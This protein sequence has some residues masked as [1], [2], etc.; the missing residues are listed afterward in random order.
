M[1]R[2]RGIGYGGEKAQRGKRCVVCGDVR[3]VER[4]R[5]GHVISPYCSDVCAKRGRY[6]LEKFERAKAR[7]ARRGVLDPQVELRYE[8]GRTSPLCKHCG[9]PFPP[10]RRSDG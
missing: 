2:G 10:N 5:S 9:K 3:L 7:A 6:Y 8:I 4:M 1:V